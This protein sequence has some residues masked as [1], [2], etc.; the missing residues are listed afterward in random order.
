MDA[1][2]RQ[3][4]I[5]DRLA[6]RSR[7]LV[8]ELAALSELASDPH[9]QLLAP[10]GTVRTG[11]QSFVGE[12]AERAFDHVRFDT[13]VLACC[14]LDVNTGASTHYLEDAR[15]KRAA[16]AVAGRVL[17]VVTSDKLGRVAF[18]QVCPITRI[19]VVL[20]NAAATNA[21][22]KALQT[23]GTSVHTI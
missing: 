2:V 23:A 13:L 5:M 19:D 11:E 9:T 20:T 3:K 7:V 8:A 6:D 12:H 4:T 21:Q 16:L 17:A 18:G 15:F 10:G 22:G 14:G 1:A